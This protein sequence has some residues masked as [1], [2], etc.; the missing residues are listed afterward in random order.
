LTNHLKIGVNFTPF[1][2]KRRGGVVYYS[3]NLL[4]EL[5][6]LRTCEV[7]IFTRPDTERWLRNHEWFNDLSI[8]Q[9]HMP[10]QILEHRSRFD[11]LLNLSYRECV[12]AEGLPVITF[13][14]DVQHKY[15]PHFWSLA[16]LRYRNTYYARAIYHST[17]L[18]TPSNYSKRTLLQNFQIRQDKVKVVSHGLHP[19]FLEST[20]GCP[21]IPDLP[22]EAG[23]YLFYPANTW[24]HKNHTGL[25][26]ALLLLREQCG[27]EIPLILTGQVL[28]GE[29]NHIDV[30]RETTLRGLENQVFHLGLVP[31]A[32]LKQLYVNATALVF[33]SF[34]EGFGIPLVEAMSCGCPVIASQ[35]SSLPEIAGS[36]GFYFNPEDPFDIAAKIVHFLENPREA[37]IRKQIGKKMATFFTPRRVAEAHLSFLEEAYR[38][39]TSA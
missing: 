8:I 20:A 35:R 24:K 19:I 12:H 30:M 34:F 36:A 6:E 15:Y 3:L 32:T 21:T 5:A 27:I 18:I 25:L 1:T 22:A 38:M 16:A 4:R 26:E 33:P 31:V 7:V 28:Q 2:A 13:V 11:V 17:L 29:C 23:R 39:I 9:I 10:H 37:E 14:P